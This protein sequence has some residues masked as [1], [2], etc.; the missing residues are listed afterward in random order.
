MLL[1]EREK[2]EVV[3]DITGITHDNDAPEGLGR[4]QALIVDRKRIER[5]VRHVRIERDNAQPNVGKRRQR[6]QPIHLDRHDPWRTQLPPHRRF[7]KDECEAL[8]RIVQQFLPVKAFG[9]GLWVVS[10]K[11]SQARA[12]IFGC[13][14]QA[15]N[16]QRQEEPDVV[17]IGLK[18]G[19]LALFL[20]QASPEC[21]PD[22]LELG[23]GEPGEGSEFTLLLIAYPERRQNPLHIGD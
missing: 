20:V 21:C 13:L 12:S 22:T 23:V 17:S 19:Q 9:Y 1:E 5:A 7:S 15:G 14:E 18:R 2:L 4:G 11:V 8:G 10:W 3:S 16:H 6:G